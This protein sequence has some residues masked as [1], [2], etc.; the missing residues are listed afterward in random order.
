[1]LSCRVL[2]PLDCCS[3]VYVCNACQKLFDSMEAG[4]EDF[5]TSIHASD[6]KQTKAKSKAVRGAKVSAGASSAAPAKD[7]S[8]KDSSA[9]VIPATATSSHTSSSTPSTGQA[10]ARAKA[11]G[12]S[13]SSSTK[14]I[15]L[16]IGDIP[17]PPTAT[18]SSAQEAGLGLGKRRRQEDEAEVSREL[19]E[20]ESEDEWDMSSPVVPVAG[21]GRGGDKA[22]ASNTIPFEKENVSNKMPSASKA[23]A[24]Q[25]T[26]AKATLPSPRAVIGGAGA[27]RGAPANSVSSNGSTKRAVSATRAPLSKVTEQDSEDEQRG[28]GEEEWDEFYGG[29]KSSAGRSASTS[30]TMVQQI[31]EEESPSW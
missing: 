23:T 22:K 14:S 19:F 8:A 17:S 15:R 9:K 18:K 13:T 25:G 30:S 21:K 3:L 28:E 29:G 27:K 2:A 24:S 20:D 26:A 6:D 1:M 11:S 4:C 16:S 12:P 10:K 5:C 31:N 7:S